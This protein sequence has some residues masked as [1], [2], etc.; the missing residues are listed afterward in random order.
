MIYLAKICY[1]DYNA[2]NY[3]QIQQQQIQYSNSGNKTRF[4]RDFILWHKARRGRSVEN[5]N[6]ADLISMQLI[7]Q[8]FQITTTGM[9]MKTKV[10]MDIHSCYM[11]F[12][13]RS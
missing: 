10:G 13:R 2:Y 5:L 8:P 6:R 9:Q 11:V 4:L 3:R 7:A 1:G 12:H